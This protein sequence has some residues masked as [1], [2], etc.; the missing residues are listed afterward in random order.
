MSTL[1]SW[2]FDASTPEEQEDVDD[3]GSMHS[4]RGRSSARSSGSE[5]GDESEWSEDSVDMLDKRKSRFFSALDFGL[6]E[7]CREGFRNE[8]KGTP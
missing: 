1:K 2:G 3:T 5:G 7:R 8:D 6:D 4:Q